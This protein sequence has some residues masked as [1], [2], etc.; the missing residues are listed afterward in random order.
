MNTTSFQ[1]VAKAEVWL[2]ATTLI[3]FLLNGAQIFETAAIVPRWSANPP[4]SFSLISG[5]YGINLKAFWITFHSIHEV[6]FLIAIYFCWRIE[7]VRN[8]ILILFAVHFAV[9]VWT[10]VYFAPNIIA[11]QKIFS[12]ESVA[13][14]GLVERITLWRTLNYI[15]VA[16][17]IGVSIGLIPLWYKVIHLKAMLS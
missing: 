14:V 9:R 2:L 10:L 11:F 4:E 7:P 16:I 12:D 15:R 3:Y 1:D 13:P 17:F 6:T 5:K 8:W